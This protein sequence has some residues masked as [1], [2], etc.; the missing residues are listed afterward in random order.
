MC[1]SAGR[2]IS[3]VPRAAAGPQHS[4]PEQKA[5]AEIPAGEQQ[6]LFV[7]PL[8]SRGIVSLV[9]LLAW[10]VLH[11]QEKKD[12]LILLCSPRTAAFGGLTSQYPPRKAESTA[13]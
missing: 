10:R 8:G 6:S 12:V 2:E 4:S 11:G 7:S 5:R 9:V 3:S 1:P 13:N